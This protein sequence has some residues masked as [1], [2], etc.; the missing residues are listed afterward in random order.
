MPYV[1]KIDSTNGFEGKITYFSK[2]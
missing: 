2:L 1:F